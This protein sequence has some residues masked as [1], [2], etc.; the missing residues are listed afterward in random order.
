MQSTTAPSILPC[1][2]VSDHNWITN[3]RRKIFSCAH[4]PCT[5]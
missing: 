4:S 1:P 2:A 5:V 3:Q